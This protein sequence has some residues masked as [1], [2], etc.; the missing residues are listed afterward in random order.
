MVYENYTMLYK[1]GKRMRDF[2]ER[3]IFIL[4][5]FSIFWVRF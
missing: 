2:L 1:Y 5:Q 3:F 4:V